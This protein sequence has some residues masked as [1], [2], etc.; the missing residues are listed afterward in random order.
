MG[1]SNVFKRDVGSLAAVSSLRYPLLGTRLFIPGYCRIV[2]KDAFLATRYAFR[3]GTLKIA[4][5][6]GFDAGLSRE[7]ASNLIS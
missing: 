4:L 2:D 5:D 7:S 6:L 3:T 1:F